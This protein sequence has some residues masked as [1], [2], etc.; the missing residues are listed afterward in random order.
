VDS[1]DYD[2]VQARTHYWSAANGDPTPAFIIFPTTA[3]EVSAVVQVLHNYTDFGFAME[4]GGH[5]PN[6]GFS[7]SGSGILISLPNWLR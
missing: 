5:N 7:S 3:E 4:C 6:V 2:Y 1:L